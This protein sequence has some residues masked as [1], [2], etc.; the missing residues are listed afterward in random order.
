MD[1]DEVFV[2]FLTD[3]GAG[4]VQHQA[5]TLLDHL[6]ATNRLLVAWG[7]LPHVCTAGLF[8]SFYSWLAQPTDKSRKALGEAIG[9]EAE[10]FVHIFATTDPLDL[11]EPRVCGGQV[12][13][14]TVAGATWLAA[15]TYANVLWLDL[16][17]TED[18]LARGF[19]NRARRQQMERRCT[20]VRELLA[21][22]EPM[23]PRALKDAR[24]SD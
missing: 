21:V 14:N 5:G 19:L 1:M 13:L 3:A 18:C 2:E 23:H 8:H 15:E 7:C 16:A 10:E 20:R 12:Q 9:R 11:V 24:V 4:A 22:Y 17:N 6:V